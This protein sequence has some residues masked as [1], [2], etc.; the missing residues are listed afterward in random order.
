MRTTKLM[1]ALTMA[2]LPVLGIAQNNIGAGIKFESGLS[3]KQIQ[4]KAKAENKYIFVD[5]NAT[6]C[7][8][9]KWMDANIFPDK[10]VG[11]YMNAHFINVSVQ[12]DRTSKDNHRVK[13]WYADA[14]KLN[15]N[16]KVGAYPT[17]LFFSPEAIALHRFTGLRGSVKAF[18]DA[19]KEA[20]DP[21]KQYYSKLKQWKSNKNDTTFLFNA[22]RS[23][24]KQYDTTLADSIGEMYLKAQPNLLTRK[25]LQIIEACG[26][27]Q[28]SKDKWF[29]LLLKNASLIDKV[30]N[31]QSWTEEKLSRIIFAER[32]FK[33]FGSEIMDWKEISAS[34]KD[35]YPTIGEKLVAIS[36]RLYQ[37]R[38]TKTL[39][40]AIRKSS[41]ILTE[42]GWQEIVKTLDQEFPEYNYSQI[43][44]NE[45]MGYYADK[46]LWDACNNTAYL[47]IKQFGEKISDGEINNISW[48]YIFEHTSDKKILS[49][50]ATRMKYSVER[51]STRVISVDTYANLLYKLG[52]YDQAIGW[53]N[54]AIET[55]IKNK[56]SLQDLS[57]FKANLVKMQQHQP[58]WE[59]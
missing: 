57:D 4:E 34:M 6:W 47:L 43:F 52:Q 1:I 46:K 9:C 44:L 41:N 31:D 2:F 50:A 53:E 42:S 33:F 22:Y 21:A 11:N 29:Q 30:M 59:N 7:G 15:D 45:K 48:D 13:E 55:S 54:K 39:R 12:M 24:K 16:Y 26:L 20:F 56:D 10:E 49:E 3:W 23:A 28:T 51:D 58:T 36:E 40:A 35:S 27:V 5:C 14:S 17:Y 19:V 38:I 8:P 18:L 25:N 37:D 32:L